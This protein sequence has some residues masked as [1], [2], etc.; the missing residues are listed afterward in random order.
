MAIKTEIL[1]NLEV[2]LKSLNI[3]K[4]VVRGI[5]NI[6]EIRKADCPL[7]VFNSTEIVR[8]DN[9]SAFNIN[10]RRMTVELYLIDVDRGKDY[11]I[12][13]DD[14]EES[15]IHFIECLSPSTLSDK[16]FKVDFLSSNEVIN[17][18]KLA[19]YMVIAIRMAIYYR[20]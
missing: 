13:Y 17:D 6:G 10:N 16:C 1:T 20:I 12:K 19:G 7:I 8:D 15:L 18:D 4:K 2:Q 3:A 5:Q 11:H 9:N 14:Y